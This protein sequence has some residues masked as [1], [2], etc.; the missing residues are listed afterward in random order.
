MKIVSLEGPDFSGKSTLANALVSKLRKT[1]KQVEHMA[2]PSRMITGI[3]TELLRNSKDKVNPHV[4]ALVYAADHLH[5]YLS[6]KDMKTDIA[7]LERGM[8]SF[9]VYQHLVLGVDKKWMDEINKFNGTV[10]DIAVVVKVPVEELIRRSRMRAGLKD[11]FEKE[12]FIRKVAE[13]FYNLPDWLVKRYKV[14]YIDY[15]PDTEKLV[16]KIVKLL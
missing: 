6:I 12:K 15:D 2:L 3:F 1:G 7:V 8:I 4:Y 11:S 5:H 14:V 13:T 9:F 10:P 16:E